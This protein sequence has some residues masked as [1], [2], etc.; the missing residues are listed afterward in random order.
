M[1]TPLLLLDTA[2]QALG[3]AALVLSVAGG[4]VGLVVAIRRQG[5]M[6]AAMY[7]AVMG[8]EEAKDRSGTIFRESQPGL[9]AMQRL[10]GSQVEGVD[11]KVDALVQLP[12]RVSALEARTEDHARILTDHAQ[13]IETLA[14]STVERVITRA[15]SVQHLSMLDRAQGK[16]ATDDPQP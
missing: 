8:Q 10:M 11:R 16:P 1:T 9:A 3:F 2:E 4:A 14:A 5:R 13:Q 6:L 12:Q 15:E 7:D